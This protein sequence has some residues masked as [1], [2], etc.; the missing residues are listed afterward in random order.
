LRRRGSSRSLGVLHDELTRHH[1]PVATKRSRL[2]IVHRDKHCARVA[3]TQQ[4]TPLRI[5]PHRL[6][7]REHAA[8]VGL[9]V[10]S[11]AQP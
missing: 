8:R 1:L 11:R 2:P 10:H 4:H 9:P 5:E 3:D 6:T 7:L